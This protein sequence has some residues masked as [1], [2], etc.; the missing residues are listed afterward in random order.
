[1]DQDQNFKNVIQCPG[2]IVLEPL[3]WYQSEVQ[4]ITYVFEWPSVRPRFMNMRDGLPVVVAYTERDFFS[5]FYA[6]MDNLQITRQLN[7]QI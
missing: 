5:F 1:M 7:S 6:K 2:D 4:N 3:V